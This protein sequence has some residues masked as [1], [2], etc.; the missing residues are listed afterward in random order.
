MPRAVSRDFEKVHRFLTK[1]SLR[2]GK[3]SRFTITANTHLFEN[4]II[5]SFGVMELAAFLE[6]TFGIE[7]SKKDVGFKN[8][9]N[10][11]RI[12][13]FIHSKKP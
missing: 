3:K 9:K 13:K 10:I 2:R 6:E 7:I 12:L 11:N 1:T 5:D 4:Q 8:F